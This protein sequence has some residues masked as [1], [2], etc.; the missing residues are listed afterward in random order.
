MTDLNKFPMQRGITDHVVSG[1]VWLL[2]D[3]KIFIC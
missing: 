3:G 2:N 1:R